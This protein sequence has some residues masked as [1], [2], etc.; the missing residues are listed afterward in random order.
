MLADLKAFLLRGNVLDLAVAV[1]LGVAFGGI[2]SAFATMLLQLVGS[3]FSVPDLSQGVTTVRGADIATGAFVQAIIN[4]LIVG[5]ALF[6]V[7]R[8]AA[9]LERPSPD[10][11]PVETDEVILLREIRDLLQAQARR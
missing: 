2:V 1:I 4:F 7:V 6:F 5:T 9:R 11:T 3:L 8:L 10:A